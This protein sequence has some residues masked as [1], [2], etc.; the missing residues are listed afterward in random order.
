MKFPGGALAG[1]RSPAAG[2]L[3]LGMAWL[4]GGAKETGAENGAGPGWREGDAVP[5]AVAGGRARFD[6]PS[7]GPAA[8]V[9]VIVSP[10]ARRPGPYPIR[11][12]AR[13][14]ARARPPATADD[15]PVREP[16]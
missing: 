14:V 12:T 6:W 1:L 11:L 15:G 8:R 2:V 16:R 7:K 9:L 5:V 4:G 13:P 10:L 3:L